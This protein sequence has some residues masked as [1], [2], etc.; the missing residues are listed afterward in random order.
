MKEL[1][2]SEL[3]AAYGFAPDDF[4]LFE[5]CDKQIVSY[6]VR[7]DEG[8]LI[9]SEPFP[10]G[11]YPLIVM[12]NNAV[13]YGISNLRK[14]EEHEF[15]WMLAETLLKPGNKHLVDAVEKMCHDD[16]GRGDR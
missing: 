7:T 5:F 14:I 3:E 12:S 6:L 9:S 4:V 10:T 1:G 13:A 16:L 11:Y 8:G 15:I 2:L